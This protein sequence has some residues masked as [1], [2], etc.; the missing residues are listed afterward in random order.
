MSDHL[1]RAACLSKINHPLIIQ[2][3]PLAP[4]AADELRV[5]ILYAGINFYEAMILNGTY[6]S[7]PSPN[8]CLGGECL[9]EVI[10]KG[11]KVLDFK[12]GDKVVT[13]AQSGYGTS[14]TFATE[15]NIK[16][17][18]AFKAP[19]EVPPDLMAA[20]PMAYFTA[21]LL[22]HTRV[23]I[24]KRM[25]VL[26]HSAAG[27][28]GM[29]LINVLRACA[30]E[31]LTIIG[32]CSGQSKAK[33]LKQKGVDLAIDTTE[34]SWKKIVKQQYRT[35]VDVIFDANGA[36][37]WD[38]NLECLKQHIGQICS[39]GAY[40][41]PITDPQLVTKLRKK[42]LTLSGFLMWPLI[43][44]RSLSED[45]FRNLFCLLQQ[46][47]IRPQIDKIFPL[48]QI[49]KAFDHLRSRKSIGKILIQM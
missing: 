40:S 44:N 2:D 25:T 7:I 10:G 23:K 3:L 20:L 9:G 34:S 32:T 14:G 43:E 18:Y 26:I 41:G 29:A 11:S 49:N 1:V 22:A 30:W 5:R 8:H 45:V 35:G 37:Y 38:D 28:V 12:R 19:I 15:A 13:L 42:N 31:S 27:G 47:K 36:N 6:P 39:Y 16:A 33:L 17:I 46:D 4:I 48:D 21:W 24:Q